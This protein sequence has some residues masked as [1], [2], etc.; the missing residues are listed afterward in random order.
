MVAL[1]FIGNKLS[2]KG[3]TWIITL[4]LHTMYLWDHMAES[5]SLP[6]GSL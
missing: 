5:L 3:E 2:E 4:H 1:T 6:E